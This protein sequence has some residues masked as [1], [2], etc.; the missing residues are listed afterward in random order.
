MYDGWND[1]HQGVY[2][3]IL[4]NVNDKSDTRVFV[5]DAAGPYKQP[6]GDRRRDRGLHQRIMAHHQQPVKSR[7]SKAHDLLL[8]DSSFRSNWI[9]LV[10][11]PRPVSKALVHVAHAVM[12]IIFGACDNEDYAS[13]RPK[14]LPHHKEHWGLNELG[15]FSQHGLENYNRVR[16]GQALSE[17]ALVHNRNVFAGKRRQE[18]RRKTHCDRLQ[19]RSSIHVNVFSKEGQV[20]RFFITPMT[21]IDGSHID[22]TIPRTA[23]LLYGLHIS[24]CANFQFDLALGGDHPHPYAIQ[25]SSGRLACKLGIQMSGTYACGLQVGE[26]FHFWIQCNRPEAVVKAEKLASYM[27][28]SSEDGKV[29]ASTITRETGL[30]TELDSWLQSSPP[31]LA[32]TD[33]LQRPSS[34]SPYP[35]DQV[36]VASNSIPFPCGINRSVN[37]EA[38]A[39]CLPVLHNLS[40]MVRHKKVRA[41]ESVQN[42]LRSVPTESIAKEITEAIQPGVL[43]FL[44]IPGGFDV[45]RIVIPYLETLVLTVNRLLSLKGNLKDNSQGVYADV[46]TNSMSSDFRIYIGSA[47]GVYKGRKDSG[48]CRRIK[49]HIASR[50]K[51]SRPESG[52]IH[53]QEL[54]KETS[55]TNFIILVRFAKAVDPCVVRIAEA[56]MTILF[57]TW[58][59][60]AFRTLR[61]RDLTPITRQVG[62]NNANPLTGGF[63]TLADLRHPDDT[64][65]REEYMKRCKLTGKKRA[66]RNMARILSI[67]KKG[68]PAA[69][70]RRATTK[71][72]DFQYSFKALKQ[73]LF[74]PKELA[75]CLGLDDNSKLTVEYEISEG[76]PHHTP[77]ASKA[78]YEDPG[79]ALGIKLKGTYRHGPLEGLDLHRWLESGSLQAVRKARIIRKILQD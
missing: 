79:R 23:G 15:S 55:R 7:S 36:A 66:D 53:A 74:I 21:K 27:R 25:A 35:S 56:L 48:L 34:R 4:N 77:Y 60:K 1:R 76:R 39:S 43:P 73:E 42:Y 78:R 71:P 72:G 65:K 57:G 22:I 14:A 58:D 33:P 51:G 8:Q 3:N 11:F 40:Q 17:V 64:D 2:A 9:I 24:R 59:N 69:I 49:E 19:Q 18:Q 62:L 32:G 46:V 67:A 37:H 52:M 45:F 54:S 61:P 6:L 31:R 16:E 44:K 29:R 20:K 68:G 10:S 12:T 50:K 47:A 63:L 28:D 30:S 13:C 41:M 70:I 38:Y 5:G 26:I 75:K